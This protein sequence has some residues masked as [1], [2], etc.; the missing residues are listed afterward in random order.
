[1]HIEGRYSRIPIVDAAIERLLRERTLLQQMA[2]SC[3]D[4]VVEPEPWEE[5]TVSW[6]VVQRINKKLLHRATLV[7][8][9]HQTAS[10]EA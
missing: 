7:C 9:K 3:P 8:R 5:L 10:P 6:H 4:K 2:Q 1:M